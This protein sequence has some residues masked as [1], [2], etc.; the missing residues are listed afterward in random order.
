MSSETQDG[1]AEEFILVD[2]LEAD[3]P[4]KKRSIDSGLLRRM[5][6]VAGAGCCAVL[7]LFL[8]SRWWVLDTA[9]FPRLSD[10]S[11]LGKIEGLFPNDPRK[12]TRL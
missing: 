6:L 12:Y 11:Y 5:V 8:I 9:E 2:E 1:P 3:S 10:G 7:L 4:P